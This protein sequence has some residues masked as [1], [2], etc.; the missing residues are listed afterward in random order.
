MSHRRGRYAA[1]LNSGVRAL[2]TKILVKSLLLADNGKPDSVR[3]VI[4]HSFP[5]FMATVPG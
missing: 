2:Q 1:R 4:S 5:A 3:A